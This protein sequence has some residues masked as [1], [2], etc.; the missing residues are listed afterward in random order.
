MHNSVGEVKA[1]S[2]LKKNALKL[3]ML[4]ALVQLLRIIHRGYLHPGCETG[5]KGTG[6]PVLQGIDRSITINSYT[7]IHKPLIT[8]IAALS[9]WVI[10]VHSGLHCYGFITLCTSLLSLFCLT[11]MPVMNM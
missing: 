7:S 9:L 2:C 3:F 8:N 11:E 10:C 4:G 5:P 1:L 6:S